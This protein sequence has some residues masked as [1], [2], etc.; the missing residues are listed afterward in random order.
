MVL[1]CQCLQACLDLTFLWIWSHA[2][3]QN[4]FVVASYWCYSEGWNICF[5]CYI[6]FFDLF[7]R[8]CLIWFKVFF[9]SFRSLWNFGV[10]IIFQCYLAGWG[11]PGDDFC[12]KVIPPPWP[13]RNRFPVCYWTEQVCN[14]LS[15]MWNRNKM[16][17]W[18]AVCWINKNVNPYKANSIP[19]HLFTGLSCVRLFRVAKTRLH[20][21]L[22]FFYL[23]GTSLKSQ[24]CIES[25]WQ[26]IYKN[27]TNMISS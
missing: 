17:D 27:Q 6:Q 4:A 3:R 11:R 13:I 26:C 1:S 15:A 18:T 14:I 8:L 10:W 25:K 20:F 22:T 23:T 2:S 24:H 16:V 21:R 9:F 12:S 19:Q 5:F 7:W